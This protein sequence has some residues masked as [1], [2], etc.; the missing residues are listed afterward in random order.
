MDKSNVAILLDYENVGG[1]SEIR[2]LLDLISGIG[3]IVEKRAYGD[4]S[5]QQ[6]K[7]Q[8]QLLQLGFS[9]IHQRHST[10]GKNSSDIKLSIDAMDL[11]HQSP[12]TIDTF[13]IVSSDSDF[14]PLVNRLRSSGKMVIVSGRQ[15]ST[16]AVLIN[17]CDRFIALDANTSISAKTD[18]VTIQKSTDT[19]ASTAINDESSIENGNGFS[20]AD[21]LLRAMEASMDEQG[22]VK[23]SMLHDTMR[24]IDPGFDFKKLGHRTFMRFLESFNDVKVVRSDGPGD[25]IIQLLHP[26]AEQHIEK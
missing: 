24:R 9:L 3:A 10:S 17:S 2:F 16:S 25:M 21:L 22:N 23:G 18:E 4:W 20:P 7:E 11:L 5:V 1:R 13:V 26:Q 8:D 12:A 19:S 15:A 14:F 6:R